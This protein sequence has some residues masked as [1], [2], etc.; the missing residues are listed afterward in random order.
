MSSVI[1]RRSI[2]LTKIGG[3]L[4]PLTTTHDLPMA[5]RILGWF[6]VGS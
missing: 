5:V 4:I 3:L 2:V 1:S 6:F